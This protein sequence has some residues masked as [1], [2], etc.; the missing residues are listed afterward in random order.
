MTSNTILIMDEHPKGNPTMDGPRPR[1]NSAA[2]NPFCGVVTRAWNSESQRRES[3][4]GGR[5]GWRGAW[6]KGVDC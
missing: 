4:A 2:N 3:R 6:K 5:G 1:D